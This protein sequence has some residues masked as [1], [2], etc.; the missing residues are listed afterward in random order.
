[1]AATVYARLKAL[2]VEHLGVDEEEVIPA[3]SF[4]EDLN[5][6]S[7]ELVEL[8]SLVEE[9]FGIEIPNGDARRLQ[10]VQDAVEYIE[11]RVG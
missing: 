5:A 9:E 3:A 7:L 4:T 10:T 11:E 1:M 2:I 8:V 6:D